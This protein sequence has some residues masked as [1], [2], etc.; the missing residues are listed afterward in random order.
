MNEAAVTERLLAL[1]R[2]RLAPGAGPLAPDD[3]LFQS[4]GIDSVQALDLLSAVELEFGVEI[5]D[6][7]LPEV[8]TFADLARRVV[9]RL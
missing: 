5:P 6:Y 7:E 4:L 8:R 2:R 9:E 3:D 1:A